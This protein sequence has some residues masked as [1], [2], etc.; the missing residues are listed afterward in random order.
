M[1]EQ[2]KRSKPTTRQGFSLKNLENGLV[3]G[4]LVQDLRT[5]QLVDYGWTSLTGPASARSELVC[6][7]MLAAK[8]VPS[9]ASGRSV[10]VCLAMGRARSSPETSVRIDT[11]LE[12]S[13]EGSINP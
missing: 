2:P 7:A 5:Q 1:S 11:P 9:G 6:L 4:Q 8:S 13:G 3:R 12:V 10:A